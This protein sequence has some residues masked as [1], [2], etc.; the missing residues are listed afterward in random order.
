M[1]AISILLHVPITWISNYPGC[2]S[3]HYGGKQDGVVIKANFN[4]STILFSTFLGG[5][6]DDAAFVL[7]I[8]PTNG[9]LFIGGNTVSI[10]LPGDKGG[11][12]HPVS[13]VAFVMDLCR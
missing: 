9:N 12:L 4:L 7:A 10:D 13:G 3:A 6:D 2:I 8:N 5:K 11:V 1:L